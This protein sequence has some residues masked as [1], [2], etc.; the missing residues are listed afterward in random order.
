[1]LSSD[2]P[3]VLLLGVELALLLAVKNVLLLSS[4]PAVMPATVGDDAPESGRNASKALAIERGDP[5]ELTE[6]SLEGLV[7]SGDAGQVGV[8]VPEP[9]LSCEKGVVG[10]DRFSQRRVFGTLVDILDYY[11]CRGASSLAAA[12]SSQA[13]SLVTGLCPA[14]RWRPACRGAQW[15]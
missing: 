8:D 7:G 6:G 13:A 10:L 5:G 1:M 11:H 4:L 9:G 2:S 15:Q 14:A 12:L 3:N